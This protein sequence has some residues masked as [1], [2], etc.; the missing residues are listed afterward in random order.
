MDSEEIIIGKCKDLFTRVLNT[1]L[2]ISRKKEEEEE[3]ELKEKEEKEKN[4]KI[5]STPMR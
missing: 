5:L 3:E 4:G 1:D 2:F